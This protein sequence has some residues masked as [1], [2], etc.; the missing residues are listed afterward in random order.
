[1]A[2]WLTWIEDALIWGAFLAALAL[3]VAQVVLRYVF[4]TGFVWIEANL[5]ALTILAGLAGGSRAILS[6]VHVRVALLPDALRGRTRIAVETIALLLT[7]AFCCLCLAGGLLYMQF[8]YSAGVV[9]LETGLPAWIYAAITPLTML[10]YCLRYFMQLPGTLRGE[11]PLAST[12]T[13]A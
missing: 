5:V 9:S 13:D 10:M 8:L 3:G 7:I 1:M 11:T 12:S 2:R 4:N 6:G